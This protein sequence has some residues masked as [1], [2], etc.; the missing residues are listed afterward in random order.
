VQS[1]LAARIDLLPPAEKA[2]LQAAAVIGP[3]FWNGPVRTLV[4][5]DVDFTVLQERDFVR[6]RTTSTIEGEQEL[7]FKHA[8]TREVAYASI[9]KARRARLHAAFASWLERAGGGRDEH[10]SL[11]AHHYAEAVRPEHADLAWDADPVEHGRLHEKALE[12]L[13]RAGELAI[14][15]YE[16]NAAI[17]LLRRAAELADEGA[18]AEI[19]REIGRANALK[20]DAA[21]FLEAM[22][23]SLRTCT[24]RGVC[25]E[26][27][28][29]LAFH[30]AVR[31]G[32]WRQR[33]APELVEG[34][35]DRA[36]ELTEPESAA[37][38]RA[39]I[40][41]AHWDPPR[42]DA[43][44][45]ASAIGDRLGDLE[46]SSWALEAQALTAF[47]QGRFHDAADWSKKRLELA[48]QIDDPDH[49]VEIYESAV[50]VAT[51]VGSFREARRLADLH[52]ELSQRLSP[53]HRLHGVSL[54]AELEEQAG[55][56]EEV[57]SLASLVERTVEGNLETPCLRNARTLLVC[58]LASLCE[59]DERRALEL[60]RKALEVELGGYEFALAPVRLRLALLRGDLEEAGRLLEHEPRRAFVFGP[61]TIAARLDALAALGDR[62]RVE[63]EAPG[64]THRRSYLQPFALRALGVVRE[65]DQLVA[66]ALEAF[67]ALGLDW[68]AAQTPAL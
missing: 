59:R 55:R 11:L 37:R 34:W 14:G 21:A 5:G 17:E 41:R 40:A 15:R 36:L 12:W 7:A 26:T 48:A 65:D 9:P 44:E 58:A 32:M 1:A 46:L 22:Q 18:R 3:V 49:L 28:S 51:A 29:L 10:A 43:A 16:L 31:S 8:L 62:G 13:R 68:H 54:V 4:G 39:L 63:Q 30:T 2:A 24:D 35:I 23:E 53:H 56:W 25:G 64:H 33:P 47:E 6:R 61:G 66:R 45:E 42:R 52:L 27:Y 60:E 20:Y 38:A 67:S 57:C 19:W 50:P